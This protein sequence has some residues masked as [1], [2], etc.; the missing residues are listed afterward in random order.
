MSNV[1]IKEFWIEPND[2]KLANIDSILVESGTTL[3][4]MKYI[5]NDSEEEL[6]IETQ[7]EVKIRYKGD[8]YFRPQEYTDELKEIIRNQSY[9]EEDLDFEILDN[10]WCELFYTIGGK[11]SFDGYVCDGEFGETEEEIKQYFLDTIDWLENEK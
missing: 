11:T 2:V 6:S 10:N 8:Y 7:G 3:A 5:I 9:L 4:Y 1:T